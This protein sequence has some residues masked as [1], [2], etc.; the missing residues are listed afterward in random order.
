M[1]EWRLWFGANEMA[2]QL[3]AKLPFV[4]NLLE[5]SRIYIALSGEEYVCW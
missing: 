5:E 2:H 1:C 4:S 3:S